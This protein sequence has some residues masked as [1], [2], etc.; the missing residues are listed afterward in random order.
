MKSIEPFPF[1]LIWASHLFLY[2]AVTYSSIKV[3]SKNVS[4]TTA[5]SSHP[6]HGKTEVVSGFLPF[7]LLI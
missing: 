1:W 6:Q 7:F 2:Q 3:S 4:L 5:R